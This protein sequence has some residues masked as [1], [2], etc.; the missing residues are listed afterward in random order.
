MGV[1]F[2]DLPS[3]RR[4]SLSFHELILCFSHPANPGEIRKQVKRGIMTI[5]NHLPAQPVDGYL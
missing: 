5:S 2:L 3:R 4:L 1:F